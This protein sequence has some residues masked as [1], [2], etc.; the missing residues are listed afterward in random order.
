LIVS[1]K[2]PD[3]LCLAPIVLHDRGGGSTDNIK[4]A[5][6]AVNVPGVAVLHGKV[7]QGGWMLLVED[8][9]QRDTGMIKG[10]SLEMEV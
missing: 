9:A 5:F 2:P 1:I 4:R 10:F 6:D 3:G 8:K 7:P